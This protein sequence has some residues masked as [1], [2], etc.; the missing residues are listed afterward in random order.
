MDM[1]KACSNSLQDP[2]KR[3]VFLA[4]NSFAARTA[5]GMHV[6]TSPQ[7]DH[8]GEF[9]TFKLKVQTQQGMCRL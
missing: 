3:Q 2:V 4:V 9:K 6:K 7:L 5:E 8:V 1:S